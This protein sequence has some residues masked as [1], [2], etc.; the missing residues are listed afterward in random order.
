M[1]ADIDSR[2]PGKSKYKCKD[3]GKSKVK[4]VKFK[5]AKP[6][7]ITTTESL[8]IDKRPTEVLLPS[9]R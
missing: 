1:S 8:A 5:V 3:V 2:K 9:F 6:A 4:H 7:K